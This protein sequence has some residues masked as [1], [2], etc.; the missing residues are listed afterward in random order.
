MD[1]N[2]IDFSGLMGDEIKNVTP[3]KKEVKSLGTISI[4]VLADMVKKKGFNLDELTKQWV[5]KKERILTLLNNREIM[6]PQHLSFFERGDNKIVV[7][8]GSKDNA[9]ATFTYKYGDTF[10]QQWVKKFFY[11]HL[12]ANTFNIEVK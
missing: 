7:Y 3:T 10:I 11:K 8:Q 1:K 5:V 9:M 12:G 6:R 2:N 4:D